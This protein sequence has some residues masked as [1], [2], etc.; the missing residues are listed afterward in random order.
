MSDQVNRYLLPISI[1]ELVQRLEQ[2]GELVQVV[3]LTDESAGLVP[4][5]LS[6]DSRDV[7]PDTLFFCKGA[8]FKQ[9]YLAAAIAQGA[10][11]YISET[12]Y[13]TEQIPVL[14]VKDATRAMALVASWYYADVLRQLTLIGV[15]GTKGKSTTVYFIKSILDSWMASL[16]QPETAIL[17][18]IDNYDGVILEESHLTTKESLDL[19]RH[20]TNAVS[21]GIRYL[22]MEVSSQAL[23]YNRV[24]H[25]FFTVSCFTNFGL[26]HISDI[27][28]HDMEDYLS[29][30]LLIF[31]QSQTTCVNTQTAEAER[32]LAA[33]VQADRLITYGWDNEAEVFAIDHSDAGGSR[34]SASVFGE[35]KNYKLGLAGLFNVENALAAISVASTLGVPAEHIEKGLEAA[36]VPGRMEPFET[37][38]GKLVLVDYAHNLM[39][40]EALFAAIKTSYAESYI[41]IVFGCPGYKALDR[42]HDLGMVSGRDADDVVLTEEDAGA[43]PLADICADIA[44]HVRAQG[45]EPRI[46]YDREAA[47]RSAIDLAPPGAVILVTGK[48][49]ETRQKRGKEYIE[50]ISDVE[51]VE[52]Y[53]KEQNHVDKT[54]SVCI[55]GLGVTGM[56]LVRHFLNLPEPVKVDA[57]IDKMS[58]ANKQAIA[59]L[60]EEFFCTEWE[61]VESRLDTDQ[62]IEVEIRQT[63]YLRIIVSNSVLQ[64]YPLGVASPG[65]KPHYPIFVS[66]LENCDELIGEPE[67]AFRISPERWLAVTGT[68]GKTTTTSLINHLMLVS[69]R[70]SSV[71]GNIGPTL[72]DAVNQREA[73]D[74]LAV[75]LSSYQL[76]N[77]TS[78]AP[79]A[80]VLLNI[81]PDHL[82]WH[83]SF[84]AYYAAKMLIFAHLP[85]DAPIVIDAVSEIGRETIVIARQAGKRVIGL[86][87]SPE[88]AAAAFTGF[89]PAEMAWVDEDG[90]LTLLI[91]DET[92]RVLPANELLIKGVHNNLNAL[93][94]AAVAYCIEVSCD[95]IKY[96]LSSFKALEH[97]IEPA[98]EIEGV[99]FYNDSKATNPEATLMALSAFEQG[100]IILMLGGD[101]KGTDLTD[102][103]ERSLE[104][105]KTVICYG[106]AKDR[107]LAAFAAAQAEA[108]QAESGCLL[109]SAINMQAAFE[110]AV[111]QANKGDVILLS[112]ACASFDEFNNFEERGQV[113]K[114][115]ASALVEE[116]RKAKFEISL[117]PAV[118]DLPS[119]SGGG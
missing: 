3:G 87:I 1:A 29:A 89:A 119:D 118:I 17:S 93:A 100:K 81:T 76:A 64:H 109:Y 97:R 45:K 99:S 83:G 5:H 92:L 72:I 46:I 67:L 71:A 12:L 16:G 84:E 61:E 78:I 36:R 108:N 77:S 58:Q 10:I 7:L 107:F 41:A 15:T 35:Q 54:S 91:A 25:V 63:H 26:D 59:S 39:S 110:L 47:I 43:E 80:A 49:R 44:Q 4:Q 40:F 115:Y 37:P 51:I 57:Y 102:L 73:D 24:A 114:Q 31:N 68:N 85:A 111:S 8:G 18:S 60:A 112:P 19:Y 13:Q 98:G 101:D 52:N 95:D 20:F 86:G 38:D 21:S 75:E 65:I 105:C 96:G 56:G 69:G 79:E 2:A 30:K 50:V 90:Y 6:Y 116:S 48:G 23:R 34:F 62:I 66:A 88:Q 28:H 22:S 103:V 42:R 94:A 32:V 74:W 113:F 70:Q 82:D 14:Q 106:Q 27:E 55:L 117:Y 33:A 104:C 53:I 9:E 11:A